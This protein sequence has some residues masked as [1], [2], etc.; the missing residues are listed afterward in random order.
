M[1]GDVGELGKGHIAD[2]VQVGGGIVLQL[3]GHP[4]VHGGPVAVGA[5]FL[6]EEPLA[7]ELH[8]AGAR[9]VGG[10]CGTGPADVAAVAGAL[11]NAA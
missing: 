3:T 11:R 5:P 9:L 6:Q 2:L 4:L 1:A 10:C 7:R 8:A